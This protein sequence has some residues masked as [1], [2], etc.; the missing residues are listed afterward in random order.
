[1]VN[2]DNCGYEI[3]GRLKGFSELILCSGCF[4]VAEANGQHER[5]ALD[6]ERN[7]KK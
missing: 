7:R 1:M 3:V 2:C 5:E 6:V 4:D